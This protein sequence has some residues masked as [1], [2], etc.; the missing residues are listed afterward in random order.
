MSKS[1]PHRN[2]TRHQ[3]GDPRSRPPMRCPPMTTALSSAHCCRGGMDPRPAL[4]PPNGSLPRIC[5]WCRDQIDI[6]GK[7]SAG[8]NC[9][10]RLGTTE[11]A[12]S[13]A[14]VAVGRC[15]SGGWRAA[16]RRLSGNRGCQKA[17]SRRCPLSRTA[18]G[19]P[20]SYW[21]PV[22]R[23]LSRQPRLQLLTVRTLLG[24]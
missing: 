11:S 13:S 3:S 6:F 2:R 20:L 18:S 4:M 9:N 21:G 23:W 19:V 7:L 8:S 12:S 22:A 5:N 17:T 24:H 14:S 15:V 1:S 16:M 10:A